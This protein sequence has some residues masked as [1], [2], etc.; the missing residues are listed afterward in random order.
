MDFLVS[1]YPVLLLLICA[2][3]CGGKVVYQHKEPE[4]CEGHTRNLREK[5]AIVNLRD[6]LAHVLYQLEA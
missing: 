1:L 6:N 3:L 4:A 5:F 2:L